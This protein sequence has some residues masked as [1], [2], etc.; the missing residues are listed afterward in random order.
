[1]T[2]AK[3][4][5]QACIAEKWQNISSIT[6]NILGD[7]AFC[8]DAKSRAVADGKTITDKDSIYCDYCQAPTNLCNNNKET[9]SIFVDMR[10]LIRDGNSVDFLEK[11]NTFKQGL[12]LIAED[13]E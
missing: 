8:V 12:L 13:G 7:C 3:E 2:T 9:V 6:D 10:K 5:A 11:L 1:M 4:L